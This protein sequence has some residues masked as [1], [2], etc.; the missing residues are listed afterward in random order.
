MNSILIITLIAFVAFLLLTGCGIMK[1]YSRLIL[2]HSAKMF[3]GKQG[4]NYYSELA[5]T[6]VVVLFIAIAAAIFK[7]AATVLVAMAT[8]EEIATF[9]TALRGTFS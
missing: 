8:T 7:G 9:T 2:K 4:V 1:D 5:A 3:A 6:L